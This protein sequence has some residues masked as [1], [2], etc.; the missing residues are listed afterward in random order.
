VE[1][2]E[3]NLLAITLLLEQQMVAMVAQVAVVLQTVTRL[4]VTVTLHQLL[5]RKDATVEMEPLTKALTAL[6]AEVAVLL[7]LE[8]MVLQMA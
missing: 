1:V 5:H 8:A 4:V 3:V 2:L 6:V 7:P